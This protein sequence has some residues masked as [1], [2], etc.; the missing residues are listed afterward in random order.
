MTSSEDS[1]DQVLEVLKDEQRR[2]GI[3]DYELEHRAGIGSGSLSRI[4][5]RRVTPS[6]DTLRKLC[7]ALR[8]SVLAILALAEGSPEQ[9]ADHALINIYRDLS[10]YDRMITLLFARSLRD[11]DGPAAQ[12]PGEQ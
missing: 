1:M 8:V 11:K 5:T 6:M 12:R 2:L 7:K 4:W 10:Q 3:P 9:Y